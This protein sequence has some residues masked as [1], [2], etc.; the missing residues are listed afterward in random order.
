MSGGSLNY[1]YEKL[2]EH[3][4]DFGDKEL[5]KLVRDL[6]QL[7]YS[8]EWYLSG[9]YGECK[10]NEARDKFKDKWLG[11]RM[12]LTYGEISDIIA[13]NQLVRFIDRKWCEIM[14]PIP[15]MYINKS[16]NK[17]T[18]WAIFVSN[19]VYPHCITIMLDVNQ[20]IFS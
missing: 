2:E 17:F 19:C 20:P 18:V 13:G 15:S 9:D 14:D 7:F 8:R 10:W 5:E 16:W 4:S 3:A 11:E 1:F 12:K 6:S